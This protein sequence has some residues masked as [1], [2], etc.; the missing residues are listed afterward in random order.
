MTNT[1][2]FSLEYD[3]ETVGPEGLADVELWGT[4]DQGQTWAKWGSDPDKSSPFD[5]EVNGEGTYG[6]RVVIVGNNGLA[7]NTPQ[8]GDTADIW[9]GV[10]QTR[11]TAR[12]TSAAYGSGAQAGKLDIRWEASDSN[13][14]S[15]PVTLSM[16][17]RAD[18]PFTPIA[19]GL[20]NTG[21]YFWDFDPRSPRQLY[22]RL[23]VR[24]DAGN[25]TIDQLVEPIQV[26][27]LAPKGRIRGFSPAAETGQQPFR[28]PLFR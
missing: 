28:S 18:G 25:M 10:D 3:V 4:V 27:G 6:F 14:S 5:V 11:P 1:R 9:V 23:E 16:S 19:A 12:I 24:D 17:E 2:R 8:A 13:L 7:S 22:L 15:R 26:E 21:Q 20:P